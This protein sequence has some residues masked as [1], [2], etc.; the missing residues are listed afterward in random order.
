MAQSFVGEIRMFGGNFAP[1]G[2]AFCN[3]QQMAI[4]ENEALF[5]LIGTTYG[6][7]GVSTFGLPNLQ[8]R[9]PIHVGSGFIQGQM[10]GEENHTLILQEIPNHTHT[11]EGSSQA[12]TNTVA[13]NLYGGGGLKA[14]KA[15]TGAAMNAAVVQNN[16]GG[17]PHSNMM[18]F[19]AVSFIISLFGIFPSQ[20]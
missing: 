11:V 10:A 14:Y 2:W 3:G 18:P 5:A 13:G 9:I 7:D 20:N 17:Q 16:I 15:T 8:G 1:S 4:S 6:G 12:T 19:L